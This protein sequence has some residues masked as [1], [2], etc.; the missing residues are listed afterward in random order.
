MGEFSFLIK[1]GSDKDR[2]SSIKA[3]IRLNR[4]LTFSSTPST[5]SNELTRIYEH[6]RGKD[7][8]DEYKDKESGF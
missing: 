8:E 1:P 4:Q 6:T 2:E 5:V 7:I 3:R